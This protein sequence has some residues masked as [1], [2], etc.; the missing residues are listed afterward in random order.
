MRVFRGASAY[1]PFRLQQKLLQLQAIDKSIDSLAAEYYYFIHLNEQWQESQSA[2]L[3]D[4]LT[5]S[6]LTPTKNEQSGF[7]VTPRIGTI[8][9]WSSKA[10]EII[11]NCGLPGVQ[12]AER[13]ITYHLKGAKVITDVMALL[14]DPLTE[15][16]LMD[17]DQFSLLFAEHPPQPLSTIDLL[18][19]GREALEIANQRLGL[20]L[21]A[22]EIDYLLKSFLRLKRNPTD[23]ELMMFAQVNSEHCRHK[24]FN[25]KWTIDNHPQENSLF[26]MIRQTYRE[27]P[28]QVLVAYA[29]NAAVLKGTTARRW[30]IDPQT[31][32]YS[33]TTEPAH[34]VLKVETHNHPTAI[35]PFPGAATGNGGE[36]RDEAATG[37]GACPKAGWSGFSVSHLL[38]PGFIQPWEIDPG[39][40]APMATPLEI[41]LQGPIGAAAFNN[42]FGRP[43]LAGYFRTFLLTLH[44]EYGP[45]YR[46][47]HKPIM[48]AGGVGVI[49]E[50]QLLKK[51]LPAGAQLIVLGGPAM[52][53][54]LGGGSASSRASGENA[55][56]LDFASVQRSNPEMQRRCQEVINTCWSMGKD[57]PI[58]SIHDVGAGGLSNALPEIVASSGKGALLDLRAIPNAA[59]GMTPLEIWCNEAQ[60]RFVLAIPKTE[61]ELF[62]QIARRER[63]PYAV[64]GE[65]TENPELILEDSFFKNQPVAMPMSVLFEE[66]PR[67]ACAANHVVFTMPK[68]A[69]ASLDLEEVVQRVLQFPCVGSKSFLITI[70]D[71]SV[72]GLVARDQMVGPWQVPVADVAVTSADYHGVT[73]EALAIG[74]RPPIA[75]VHQAASARMAVGEAI[76]N[77]AAARIEDITR[78]SLSANWMAA[79]DYLGEG[80]GLFD[81]VQTVALELC[82]ALGICIPV[83]KDSLSMRTLWH[84]ADKPKS[85]TSPL[86]LVIT[87]AAP[88]LDVRATLTPQLRID[89]GPTRLILLDLGEGCHCMAGSVLEQV[90]KVVTQRPPDIDDPDLLK[91]FFQAVQ[92]LN[93]KEFLLAYHDRSDGGL[94]ATLCEMMFAGHV[95][96][97]VRI[98]ELVDND[99]GNDSI[100]ALFTEELGAVIQVRERDLPA[101]LEILQRFHLAE[102]THVLGEINQADQLRIEYGGRLIYQQSRTQLHRWWA[103]TSYRM[104]A[105]RDNPECAAEEYESLLQE[106]PGL[107]VKLT[108][109]PE[110]DPSAAFLQVKSPPRVAI[111]REQ[112]V[113]GHIEMAAA[114]AR[115]GFTC[116]DVHMTDIFS[117]RIRLTDFTGIAAG[118]GFS[119]G[120]VLGAGRGWAQSILNHPQA[121]AAF[122]EFFQRPDTFTFGACNGCQMLADLKVLIPGAQHWPVFSTNRSE[123]FE[124]RV[125]L[126]EIPASPAIFLRD[127]AGSVLPVVVAHGE[128]RAIFTGA[129][130][131]E[132]IDRDHLITLRYVDHHHQVTER[133]P[134]NPNGS[135]AGITGLTTPDGRVMI[136]MPHPERVF[137]TQQNSWH[138]DEWGADGPWLR[139]FQNARVWV[140]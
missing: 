122:S 86:S 105:L 129:G 43:G 15:T 37:R 128:G 66:M 35:S 70:G 38:I 67:Q 47:Y 101:V 110:Q 19:Q 68:F 112:G 30:L 16:V 12:R 52:A 96:V 24:I 98:D 108:F 123:Q 140:N 23:V 72:T 9:P 34:I 29:D 121:R 51:E 17:P 93:Q 27:H 63:C 135:S 102:C 54:G 10:T 14:H 94:L 46:G 118:G 113:N 137:R 84:E 39:K 5:A 139:L 65:V 107:S 61:L 28:G 41:M 104:Q 36:I 119:Y 18:T 49:R 21:N 134:H 4:L 57:N 56:Q 33:E 53:I 2:T 89:K 55:R 45:S 77:I 111:L 99:L 32:K 76:T 136:V 11:Q 22:S 82:S 138:P 13:G 130:D 3:T 106:D 62:A 64:V 133:Y 20:S 103:E 8:S 127:M 90:Y 85:V 1:T 69:T 95:G 91:H 74:E 120:D 100:A 80:A 79:P 87:A 42:E 92:A 125:T 81:A 26:D 73:G 131:Q 115:A 50:S 7:W 48:I 31:K 88:V 75:I 44:T 124:G 116:I 25:A 126:V 117:G 40:P 132:K 59:P 71:R 114:F 109:K 83:G 97:T 6:P 58:L 78:I 60:E